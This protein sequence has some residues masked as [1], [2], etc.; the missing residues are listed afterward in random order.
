[1]GV[2]NLLLAV[3]VWWCSTALVDQ[4]GTLGG[5]P[6]EEIMNSKESKRDF[7]EGLR[8]KLKPE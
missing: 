8:T 3:G 5:H 4:G 2:Q 1:M 7:I 6:G